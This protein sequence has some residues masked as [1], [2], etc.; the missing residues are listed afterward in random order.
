MDKELPTETDKIVFL[1]LGLNYFNKTNSLKID[2]TRNTETEA[3]MQKFQADFDKKFPNAYKNPN[4]N[5]FE[6][7]IHNLWFELSQAG[8]D[9]IK[10]IDESLRKS[11]TIPKQ[12]QTTNAQTVAP[13]KE[14]PS[15]MS[16]NTQKTPEV[17]QTKDNSNENTESIPDKNVMYLQFAMYHLLEKFPD[18]KGKSIIA[19]GIS[20]EN[21]VE[22]LKILQK[23]L[24]VEMSGKIDQATLQGTEK[25]MDPTRN[26]ITLEDINNSGLFENKIDNTETQKPKFSPTQL[27]IQ[28][29]SKNPLEI[30]N[31]TVR[32]LYIQHALNIV[33]NNISETGA[34][35]LIAGQKDLELTGKMDD[36]TTKAIEAFQKYINHYQ[37]H[38]PNEPLEVTGK[39]NIKTMEVLVARV[40]LT[41]NSQSEEIVRKSLQDI[42]K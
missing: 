21:F 15:E 10:I 12:S 7:T 1:Q 23:N 9:T 18:L 39:L 41:G 32:N 36:R 20:D 22:N 31:E 40:N 30:P 5:P 14:N 8:F 6:R 28:N 25:A 2:G 13:K 16:Q 26:T 24:G 4:E 19:N 17:K 42:Q 29:W 3:A 34:K 38:T 33:K 27:E 37:Y 35:A 11:K